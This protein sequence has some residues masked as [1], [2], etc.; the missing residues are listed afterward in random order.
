M[1]NVTKTGIMHTPKMTINAVNE[2]P[3]KS[4]QGPIGTPAATN[5]KAMVIRAE[6]A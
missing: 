2:S 4:F 1:P 6:F 5:M 3:G